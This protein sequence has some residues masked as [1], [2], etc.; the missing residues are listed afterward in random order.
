[1]KNLQGDRF[2]RVRFA[3]LI[4]MIVYNLSESMYG[5]LST[6]WFTTLLVMVDF[7][8]VKKYVK[9]KR[10]MFQPNDESL[11]VAPAALPQWASR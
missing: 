11:P 9:K 4:V 7:P 5:R 8:A 6:I 1:M 3:V 2:Q 10:A